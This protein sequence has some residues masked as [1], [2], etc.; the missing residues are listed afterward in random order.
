VQLRG[1]LALGRSALELRIARAAALRAVIQA[2][3][4]GHGGGKGVE[5]G[6]GRASCALALTFAEVFSPSRRMATP[7]SPTRPINPTAAATA[8]QRQVLSDCTL[9]HAS[10]LALHAKKKQSHHFFLGSKTGLVCEAASTRHRSEHAT[11]EDGRRSSPRPP[12]ERLGLGFE[13]GG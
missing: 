11:S 12:G 1:T 8:A 2:Q 6:G 7:Q 13:V 3:V 4:A 5:E 10:R 9:E